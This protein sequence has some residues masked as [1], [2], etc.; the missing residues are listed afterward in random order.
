MNTEFLKKMSK[1]E[2]SCYSYYALC[3]LCEAT[4]C[5]EDEADFYLTLSEYASDLKGYLNNLSLMLR[6]LGI[7]C[8]GLQDKSDFNINNT[9]FFEIILDNLQDHYSK[10]IRKSKDLG[11]YD[12][13][14]H[15]E[16]AKF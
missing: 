15:T 3:N 6:Y 7:S 9:D 14:H 16:L 5:A 2:L 13:L 10:E 8:Q 12:S 1:T 11:G 4:R